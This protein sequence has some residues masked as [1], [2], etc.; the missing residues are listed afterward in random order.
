MNKP[1]TKLGSVSVTLAGLVSAAA[2]SCIAPPQAQCPSTG[3][4]ATTTATTTSATSGATGEAAVAKASSA[5]PAVKPKGLLLSD[6]ASDK[7]QNVD[8]PGSW[9]VFNDR[10]AKGVMTPASTGEF[11]ATAIVK[12]AVHTQGKGFSDW[13]GGIGF[14]FVGAESVTPLDASGYSGI[15]FSAS[16]STPVHVALAT[17][18][19]MPEFGECSKCYDHFAVDITDLS[20]TPKTYTFKWSQLRS[21]GWGAPKASLDTHTLIGLNF[22]SKGATAWDFSIK[23]ISFIP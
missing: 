5:P 4:T 15:S 17:I 6:G 18:A 3:T 11:G 2:A 8:P 9:F 23:N 22:T 7:I 21:A 13:G 14:N 10:T 19:T 20:N 12:G 1:F 16:G